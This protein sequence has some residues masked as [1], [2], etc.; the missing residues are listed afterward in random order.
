MTSTHIEKRIF[1]EV[2]FNNI[3]SEYSKMSISDKF[4]FISELIYKNIKK[5]SS[6]LVIDTITF[7][8]DTP[9]KSIIYFTVST[10]N[11]KNHPIVGFISRSNMTSELIFIRPVGKKKYNLSIEQLL[12]YL[13]DN[14]NIKLE[15][16]Y[17]IYL[18]IIK[19]IVIRKNELIMDDKFSLLKCENIK[20]CMKAKEENKYKYINKAKEIL[21]EY[22]S[23]LENLNIKK[24]NNLIKSGKLMLVFK[25]TKK[26]AGHL[27][28][29]IPL[30]EIIAL[31][32]F[33]Y[34][35]IQENIKKSE[36][37]T[38]QLETVE[39]IIDKPKNELSNKNKTLKRKQKNKSKTVKRRI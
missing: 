25:N 18:S 32:K 17:G 33:K 9:F 12:V 29:F 34:N 22:F 2:Q 27:E 6:G 24:A 16:L 11:N 10:K 14:H 1:I 30:Y 38:T 20:N 5:V 36:I 4:L 35:K 28:I 37:E 26:T 19:S 13:Y 7:E 15:E 8:K 21:I 3:E 39:K 31:I 23:S